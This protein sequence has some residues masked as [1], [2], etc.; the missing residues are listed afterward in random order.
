MNEQ[1]SYSYD[2]EVIYVEPTQGH[3]LI[4]IFPTVI[5]EIHEELALDVNEFIKKPFIYKNIKSIIHGLVVRADFSLLH[6][7]LNEKGR[8]GAVRKYKRTVES[9]KMRKAL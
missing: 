6:L 5:K 9:L 8:D 4:N 2:D 1:Y 7:T 3:D